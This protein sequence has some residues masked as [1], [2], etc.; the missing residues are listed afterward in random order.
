VL[1]KPISKGEIF[2]SLLG[3]AGLVLTLVD[4]FTSPSQEGDTPGLWG[5]LLAFIG[6]LAI[7]VYLYSGKNLR[8]WVPLYLYAFPVTLLSGIWLALASLLLEKEMNRVFGW[9]S[10]E[11][12]LLTGFLAIGP[13]IVGHTGINAILKYIEPV[14]VTVVLL[15]EPVIGEI[16]GYLFHQSSLPGLFTYLGGPV[17]LGGCTW[18]TI[19]A[20][21][22]T[23]AEGENKE[24]KEQEN[25][26]KE[27]EEKE[28]KWQQ[29]IGK[30]KGTTEYQRLEE[31]KSDALEVEIKTD[32]EK[33]IEMREVNS[34][35]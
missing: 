8:S 19:S 17:I 3:F 34:V 32:I 1:R 20:Y 14:V 5:D 35:Q 30:T 25:R 31:N 13:G 4:S 15:L 10:K 27:S 28:G 16:I 23:K 29:I 22:R 6:S 26:K 33:G 7:I 2:G 12:I 21:K 9:L 24:G 11:F 18:V